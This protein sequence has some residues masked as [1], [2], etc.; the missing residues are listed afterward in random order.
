MKK[1]LFLLCLFLSSIALSATYTVYNIGKKDVRLDFVPFKL[2]G[3]KP[4]DGL[5]VHI[6][7]AETGK[8]YATSSWSVP[9]KVGK[10]QVLKPDS[11]GILNP[12]GKPYSFGIGGLG[13]N[14]QDKFLIVN[15]NGIVGKPESTQAPILDRIKQL[16]MT[17][18]ISSLKNCKTNADCKK[19]LTCKKASSGSQL[20]V[21]LP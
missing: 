5:L 21:C 6:P 10:L 17:K 3:T 1:L 2:S 20:M 9:Y 19:P 13:Y 7:E 4:E 8:A 12:T 16:T 14:T 18:P 11:K 15:E